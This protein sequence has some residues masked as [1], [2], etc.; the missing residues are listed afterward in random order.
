MHVVDMVYFWARTTPQRPAIIQ[1]DGIVT[2]FALA[3]AIERSAEYFAANILDRSK[4]VTVSVSTP[5]YMLVAGL[6]LLRAGFSII[7]A[8][9]AELAHV[10]AADS[11]SLVYERG[12]ISLEERTN[13]LF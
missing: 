2:Y 13:I 8:G 7:V 5:S 4:P 9:R 6:G 12:G 10:A 1:P 3:Q 11:N